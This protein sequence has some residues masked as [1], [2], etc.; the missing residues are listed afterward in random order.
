MQRDVIFNTYWIKLSI[1]RRK[2]SHIVIL[3][4]LCNGINKLL[5][6][7]SCHRHFNITYSLYADHMRACSCCMFYSLVALMF[8][9]GLPVSAVLLD[10]DLPGKTG[11]SYTGTNDDITKYGKTKYPYP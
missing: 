9:C 8:V 11:R 10:D 2:R 6:K 7:I 3:S 4:D 1:S 5:V